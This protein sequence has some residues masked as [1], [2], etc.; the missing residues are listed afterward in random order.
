MGSNK[1]KLDELINSYDFIMY[2]PK[3]NYSYPGIYTDVEALS[4]LNY[5]WQDTLEAEIKKKYGIS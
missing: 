5:M 1:N 3:G 2:V 4:K